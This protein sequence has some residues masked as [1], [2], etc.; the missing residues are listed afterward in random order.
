MRSRRDL[1]RV[2]RGGVVLRQ[3]R[4]I[5]NLPYASHQLLHLLLKGHLI[6]IL[7]PLFNLVELAV[8]IACPHR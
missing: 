2:A 1:H 4:C 5:G 3:L 8:R 6:H 7:V